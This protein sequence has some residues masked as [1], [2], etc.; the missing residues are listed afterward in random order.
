MADPLCCLLFTFLIS[1]L[2]KFDFAREGDTVFL[3][4]EG[5]NRRQ[6]ILVPIGD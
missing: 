2:P 4:E 3:P 5:Q 1:T 6:E